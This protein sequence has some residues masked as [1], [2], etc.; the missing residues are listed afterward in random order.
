MT[1]FTSCGMPP[2]T[3]VRVMVRSS[4]WRGDV[5]DGESVGEFAAREQGPAVGGEVD[6]VDSVAGRDAAASRAVFQVWG[7]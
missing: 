1:S 3:W 7:S 5:D 4:V 2:A 6:V